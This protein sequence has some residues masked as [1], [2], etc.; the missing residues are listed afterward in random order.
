MSR[1]LRGPNL[2]ATLLFI[3]SVVVAVA[4]WSLD[5]IAQQRTFA[6][7]LSAELVAFAMMVYLYYEENPKE[8]SKRWLFAGAASI[9]LLML[10]GGAVLPNV[11]FTS[12][13][14]TPNVNIVLFEGEISSSLY[15]FGY[16]SNSLTSPGPSLIF[17]VNDI[18]NVTVTNV[19]QLPHDWA[20]VNNNQSS[21]ASV[22]FNAQIAS[23][24]NPLQHGESGSMV[25]TVTQAGNFY[26]ICQVPG[27][28]DVGMWGTVVV[29]P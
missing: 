14:S 13:A 11:S 10:L 5:L 15:G 1:Y 28:E 9:A 17:R 8:L 18:V 16:S 25:F 20:I 3:L 29:N 24:T 21:S 22:L 7:L 12:S 2:I 4:M 6:F 27:H 26:Y 19:G 23:P